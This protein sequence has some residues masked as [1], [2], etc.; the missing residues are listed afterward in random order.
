MSQTLINETDD[1]FCCILFTY[2]SNIN[3][4]L[5]MKFLSGERNEAS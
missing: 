2:T 1:S 3:S 4:F 5:K